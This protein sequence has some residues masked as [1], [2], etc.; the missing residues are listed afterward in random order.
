MDECF[1]GTDIVAVASI[2]RL[3]D[4]YP[5]KF[6]TSTYTTAEIEYCDSKKRRGEHFAGR[7]AAKEAIKKALMSAGIEVNPSLKKIEI[8]ALPDGKPEVRLHFAVPKL[9][10]CRVSISHIPEYAIA[11]AVVQGVI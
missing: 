1:I 8:I 4:R 10:I 11:M 9:L 7:F 3:L 5:E 2:E 6:R